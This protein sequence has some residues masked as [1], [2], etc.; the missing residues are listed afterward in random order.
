MAQRFVGRLRVDY[1]QDSGRDPDNVVAASATGRVTG[2]DY[3]AV[4]TPHVELTA[5]RH[6]RIWCYYE[7]GTEF[8]GMEVGAVWEDFRI[9]VEHWMPWERVAVV[10]DITWI[11][12]IVKT[13]R[14]LMPFQIR[15]YQLS[16]KDAARA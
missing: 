5:K 16:K 15:V 2:Q 13:L 8:A 12:H 6:A 3:H 9:G 1:D 11:A 10:T 4:L 14:A 7:I